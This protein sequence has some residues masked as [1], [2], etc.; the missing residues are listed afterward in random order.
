MSRLQAFPAVSS[1]QA[2]TLI[3]GS[4]PG[5]ASLAAGE[6]YA[7]PRNLFWPIIC[8]LLG[9]PPEATYAERTGRLR[10]RG[11]ALW[12]V[13]RAC[14]RSGSLDAAIDP[15]SLEIND[16]SGFLGEHP[17]ITRIFFNG[18]FAEQV[19]RKRV[20]PTLGARHIALHLTRLP[21]TSPANASIPLARKR[22]EWTQVT[23]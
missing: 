21:S 2:H 14:Q 13:L 11:F 7:H 1:P 3:L 9:I 19:F 6:Y 10:E 4:M 15:A 22:I 17:G 23:T 12:D 8:E 18:A 5:A 16:F 20:V